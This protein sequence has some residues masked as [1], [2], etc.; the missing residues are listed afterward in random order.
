VPLVKEN[1]DAPISA[2]TPPAETD[3]LSRRALIALVIFA[4]ILRLAAMSIGHTYRF[5]AH[6]DHFS[7]GWETGRLARSIASGEGFG[8]PFHGHTGPSAWIA[9]LYPY[10]L[11]GIFKA[12][13]IYSDSSAWVA[14]AF[15]SLCS[16]LN[17]VPLYLIGREL[18][19]A[20]TGKWTAWIWAVL[21]YSIYWAIRFAWETSFATLLFSITFL[22]AI[23]LEQKN[24]LSW[25][26][27]FGAL[28]ALIAL[29]N[30]SILSVLPFF[31]LWIVYR[32]RKRGILRFRH[33]VYSGLVFFALIAPWMV[34]N[35][36]IFHHPVFIRANFGAE[37]RMGNGP[38]A[39]GMW[40]FWLHPSVDPEQFAL[41][42]QVGEVDY[43]KL[44]Q[45]Q[46]VQW[47]ASHPGTFAFITLKRFLWFWFGTPRSG[48]AAEML[49]RNLLYSLSS[50]LTFVGLWLVIRQ[51]Q[52]SAFLFFWMLLVFPLVYYVTFTHPRYRHPIEPEMLLLMVY[53]VLHALEHT[54]RARPV[55]VA[56]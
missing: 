39:D 50:I 11:A 9:P 30:P 42:T 44:R 5:P 56:G 22:L 54:A 26:L 37:F 8:S 49:A 53:A 29:S 31:G 52:R 20:K 40:M 36:L 10:F 7:F 18:F 15:N 41:Y 1:A 27:R 12:F 43:V 24:R 45:Q 47:I 17:L 14:L 4:F 25:W 51:R 16:A 38:H 48:A 23:R 32:Q 21:P 34:R 33:A 2:N 13:G 19:G 35:Y 46:A 3:G 28:W 6:D 55:K